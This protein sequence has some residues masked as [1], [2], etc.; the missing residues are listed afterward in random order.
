MPRPLLLMNSLIILVAAIVLVGVAIVALRR[1]RPVTFGDGTSEPARPRRAQPL[2][3]PLST[4]TPRDLGTMAATSGR[5]GAV[6]PFAGA[7]SAATEERPVP[8]VDFPVQGGGTVTP[9]ATT[10]RDTPRDRART[11]SSKV[12]YAQVTDRTLQFVPGRLEVAEGEDDARHEIR[13]VQMGGRS[14]VTFGRNPGEPYRHV[15]L[16]SRTVS[17]L[18]ARM[19]FD[20]GQW[21]LENL[22]A[23]NPTVLNGEALTNDGARRTLR[24]GDRIEMGE[25]VFVFRER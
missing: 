24:E 12:E 7:S 5:G 6:W 19:S 23:T 20:D 14:E 16:H 8:R 18:H 4:G 1:R 13:F 21:T 15:Q 25:V 2:A 11:G 22:S 17:R 9:E 10:R 3:R